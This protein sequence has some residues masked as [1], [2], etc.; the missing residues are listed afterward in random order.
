M[1][2]GFAIASLDYSVNLVD[3]LLLSHATPPAIHRITGHSTQKSN[4]SRLSL[5]Q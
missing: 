3:S 5:V 4:L 2:K 1:S